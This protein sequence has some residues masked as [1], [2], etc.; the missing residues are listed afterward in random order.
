[1]PKIRI[2]SSMCGSVWQIILVLLYA[3]LIWSVFF[4]FCWQI[5][6]LTVCSARTR[7]WRWTNDHSK[8]VLFFFFLEKID[9]RKVLELKRSNVQP[10]FLLVNKLFGFVRFG[11]TFGSK[12]LLLKFCLPTDINS[13]FQNLPRKRKKKIIRWDERYIR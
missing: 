12:F 10:V 11:V 8:F 2:E 4:S 6:S 1:M 13:E 9:L 3:L 5:C 7:W